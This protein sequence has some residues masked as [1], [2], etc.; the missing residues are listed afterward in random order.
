[1]GE[2][3]SRTIS[4]VAWR[5][6]TGTLVFRA[7]ASCVVGGG[8]RRAI[9]V[10]WRLL[11]GYFGP[12]LELV[13]SGDSN[14]IAGIHALHGGDAAIGGADGDRLHRGLIGLHHI[15]ECA[16]RIALNGGRGNER[17]V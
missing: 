5:R 8:V 7:L 12:I 6:R 13:E 11:D 10:G 3:D 2:T 4:P 1:M 14:Q 17:G 16:L 15:N 9:A